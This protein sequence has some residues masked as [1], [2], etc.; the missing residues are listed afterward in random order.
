M[1]IDTSIDLHHDHGDSDHDDNDDID[2]EEDDNINNNSMIG[3]DDYEPESPTKKGATLDRYGFVATDSNQSSS[4]TP[5]LNQGGGIGERQDMNEQ[6]RTKKE[7]EWNNIVIHW[8]EWTRD[9]ADRLLHLTSKGIPMNARPIVWRKMLNMKYYKD[10]YPNNYFTKLYGQGENEHTEQI[11]LDIPRTYPNHQRFFSKR[12]KKDLQN[13]LQ[14]YSYH[15][16][17]VGY[18]QGMSYI[19]GVFVMYLSVEDAFWMLVALLERETM[20]YYISGMPQLISDSKLFAKVLEIEN[21]QLGNHLKIN[22]IDPLLYVTPWWMCFFTTLP[23]WGMILRIWDLIMFDGIA[24]LFRISLS[25]LVSSQSI[26]L[27]KKGAEG[28]LPFLLRPPLEDIGGIDSILMLATSY[29]IR[30]QMKHAEKLFEKEK[31]LQQQPLSASKKKRDASEIKSETSS[32]SSSTSLFEKIIYTLGLDDGSLNQYQQQHQ[33]QHQNNHKKIKNDNNEQYNP[34]PS[35]PTRSHPLDSHM[36]S[37]STSF[38]DNL[39]KITPIKANINNNIDN[40]NN[41][42]VQIS[43][44][45]TSTSTTTTNNTTTTATTTATNS[46]IT[47]RVKDFSMKLKNRF[48]MVPTKG[49]QPCRVIHETQRTTT[50]RKSIARQSIAGGGRKSI[51]PPVNHSTFSNPDGTLETSTSTV[52]STPSNTHHRS[53]AG[54]TPRMSTS[55]R[56]L[57]IGRQS[58]RSGN[59]NGRPS[60]LPG[61]GQGTNSTR[62]SIAHKKMVITLPQQGSKPNKNGNTNK[63]S[64]S[65]STT[66][67]N[68]SV[69]NENGDNQ[70]EM[71]EMTSTT[72]PTG[73]MTDQSP[74]TSTITISKTPIRKQQQQQMKTPKSKSP[75]TMKKMIDD[76]HGQDQDQDTVSPFKPKVAAVVAPSTSPLQH[77][78]SPISIPVS[79]N[80]NNSL[81]SSSTSSSL[82]K[83]TSSHFNQHGVISKPATSS[84]SSPQS[85]KMINPPPP[86]STPLLKILTPPR[87]RGISKSGCASSLTSSS[88][89]SMSMDISMA[90]TS[91]NTDIGS[92]GGIMPMQMSPIFIPLGDTNNNYPTLNVNVNSPMTTIKRSATKGGVGNRRRP[93]ILNTTAGGLNNRQQPHLHSNLFESPIRVSS[94]MKLGS[95]D[96]PIGIASPSSQERFELLGNNQSTPTTAANNHSFMTP[97]TNNTLNKKRSN[98]HNPSSPSPF[99]SNNSNNNNGNIL[100]NN[101]NILNNNNN[102]NNNCTLNSSSKVGMQMNQ[103]ASKPKQQQQQQKQEEKEKEKDTSL[104]SKIWFTPMGI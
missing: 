29:S 44:S 6:E 20:G 30:D 74:S 50:A 69:D 16:K 70:F 57:T 22:G 78:S 51:R 18:C 35:T 82:Y 68:K 26:L 84:A 76:D 13:V 64:T 77:S 11:L 45:T 5:S 91:I 47:N 42:N 2:G 94:P 33:N 80:L 9:N 72:R 89:Q 65:L 59:G 3:P 43:T 15:N 83:S 24:A 7:K 88:N 90:D 49:Y 32:S 104:F 38:D 61:Q 100:T 23:D 40:P 52:P 53:G 48:F 73:I 19:A 46:S 87:S 86:S 97:P 21:Y 102:N 92:S 95:F 75:F 4:S 10:M 39:I 8:N 79:N 93:T 67:S 81:Y 17:K 28:L 71:K 27:K 25:I 1:A 103:Q 62:K 36:P 63:T 54:A 58:I 66:S 31:E 60:I 41:P 96:S 98:T 37:N 85:F 14:A 12:G 55:A 34:I 101:Q 56:K 99:K